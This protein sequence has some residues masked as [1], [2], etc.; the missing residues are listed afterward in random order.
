MTRPEAR[1]P[2][3]APC[4]AVLLLVGWELASRQEWISPL[5]FP[6]PSAILSALVGMIRDGRL[7]SDLA[8]T[9]GRMVL[10]LGWGGGVGLVLGL[11]LGTS[12]RL[13]ALLDPFIAGIHPIPKLSLL[14]LVM[15]IFGVG[16]FSK[17][18]LVAI[19][20]FFPMVLNTMAGVRQIDSSYFEVAEIFGASRRRVFQRVVLPGALP[21][22]LVGARL[23]VT[24]SL[25]ASIAIELIT[26]EDG[27]GSMLF[28]AW[29]TFRTENLYA[30]L[31]VI[32]ALGIGSRLVIGWASR[33]LV[34]WREP[35]RLRA[36]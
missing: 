7:S 21:L 10:G 35:E 26:A 1:L 5:F 25:G 8:V 2:W 13:R 33:I 22:I 17:V 19:S 31:V 12:A 4:L 32:A 18:L 24:R 15:L 34:P 20:T 14:P 11:V 36:G 28:F 6:P 23:A 9:L 29:E 16:L 3:A 30:T 27:L